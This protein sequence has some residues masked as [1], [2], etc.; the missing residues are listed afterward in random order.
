MEKE[1]LKGLIREVF[2]NYSFEV[3]IEEKG[4]WLDTIVIFPD[5]LKVLCFEVKKRVFR[6]T[7]K[8]S[9]FKRELE[10]KRDSLFAVE[11]PKLATLSLC[12]S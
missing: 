7:Y 1:V 3:L 4:E 10:L 8:L 11:E 9:L 12:F 5:Y 6:N 2:R